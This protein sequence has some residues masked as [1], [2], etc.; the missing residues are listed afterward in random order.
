MLAVPPGPLGAEE[1]GGMSVLTCTVPIKPVG[2]ARAR[3]TSHGVYTPA[4]TVA[5]EKVISDYWQQKHHPRSRFAQDIPLI[6]EVDAYFTK[7]KSVKREDH[8]V[9]PDASNVLK[10]VEDAL[11]G[12]AYEDDSQ[13]VSVRCNKVYVEGSPWLYIVLSTT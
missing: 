9:K 5:A 10:L 13:L 11:N 6:L 1:G 4:E 3:V 2:K 8:I 7:P 12:V